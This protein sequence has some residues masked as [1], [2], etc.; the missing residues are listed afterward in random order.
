M[1]MEATS[2]DHKATHKAEPRWKLVMPSQQQQAI[3]LSI[4]NLFFQQTAKQ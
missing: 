2:V 4:K 1:K 3:K